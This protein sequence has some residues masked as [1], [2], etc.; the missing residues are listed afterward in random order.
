M[1]SLSMSS[2]LFRHLVK[3]LTGSDWSSCKLSGNLE[4]YPVHNQI[5]GLV[6]IELYALVYYSEWI[7]F[8]YVLLYSSMFNDKT[9]LCSTL[10]NLRGCW[11]SN[12]LE[13]SSEESSISD[14][15]ILLLK[16]P[17]PQD[18]KECFIGGL[19]NLVWL[20]LFLYP[21]NIAAP[22]LMGVALGA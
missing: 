18:R 15:Y 20:N 12:F 22:L 1:Q 8:K 11:L 5:H 13:L 16:I 6:P 9:F 4:S 21:V 10:H 2:I 17:D 19:E 3:S 14:W 7:Y